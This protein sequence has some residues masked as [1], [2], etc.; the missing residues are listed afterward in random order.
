MA[1][2][3]DFSRYL[4]IANMWV[5]LMLYISTCILWFLEYFYLNDQRTFVL[6]LAGL[7]LTVILMFLLDFGVHYVQIDK[8][9]EEIFKQVHPVGHEQIEH[10]KDTN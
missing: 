4:D 10:L 7:D 1:I 3:E 9:E 8:G 2:A 6:V 5:L